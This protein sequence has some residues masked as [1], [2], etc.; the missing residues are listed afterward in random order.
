M[1]KQV[2]FIAVRRPRREWRRRSVDKLPQDVTDHGARGKSGLATTM[3]ASAADVREKH[4]AD[5]L[6]SMIVYLQFHH[7]RVTRSRNN[8]KGTFSEDCGENN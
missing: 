4:L 8:K 1:I 3:P 5:A 7:A 2:R 6:V